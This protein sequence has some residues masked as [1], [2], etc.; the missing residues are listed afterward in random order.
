M[1]AEEEGPALPSGGQQR[2]RIQILM[3]TIENWLIDRFLSAELRRKGRGHVVRFYG[4]TPV[5][6]CGRKRVTIYGSNGRRAL[7][8]HLMRSN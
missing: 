1:P 3:R 8:N 4:P 6:V 5:T 2:N 7:K